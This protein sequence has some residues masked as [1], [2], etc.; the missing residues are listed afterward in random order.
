[1]LNKLFENKPLIISGPCSAE[2]R[3]QLYETAK[4]LRPHIHVLRAGI[5]KPRTK[6]NSFEGFGSEAL[7]WLKEVKTELNI[8]AAI[9]VANTKQVEEALK[10][11]I[12][13]LWIGARSSVSPFVVQEIADSLKGINIPVLVKNPINPELDLWI[14]AIERLQNVGIS[15][16]AAIHRGFSS[17]KKAPFRNEPLWD[18]PLSLREKMPNIPL[19]C[20]P[21]HICG[22]RIFLQ[23]I[24]QRALD[25]NYDGIMIESH[26]TPDKALSDAAQQ[27]TPLEFVALLNMLSYSSK[28]TKT[29]IDD[30]KI[31]H[32]RQKINSIDEMLIETISQ[33]MKVVNEIGLIKQTFHADAWQNDRYNEVLVT[34]IK[35]GKLKNLDTEF[36]LQI[37]LLLHQEAVKQQELLVKKDETK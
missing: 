30:E 34:R 7:V 4:Q 23:H 21:S 29:F 11:E 6:P 26:I 1:M 28:T 17:L 31:H 27:I 24:A 35:Q 20:D 25:L 2:S 16:I 37:Y 32:L 13:I 3:E 15:Q 18:I 19:I 5:W 12:D 8:P 22:N 36:I 14:G 9:E 33:R 10:A